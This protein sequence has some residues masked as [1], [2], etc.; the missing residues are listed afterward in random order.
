MLS[1]PTNLI[2]AG[3][4]LENKNCFVPD[5]IV[6]NQ[7]RLYY[8]LGR[9]YRQSEQA[10]SVCIFPVTRIFFCDNTQSLL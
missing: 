4:F 1:I 9:Y 10:L 7:L 2:K 8:Q 5:W 6:P 3:V